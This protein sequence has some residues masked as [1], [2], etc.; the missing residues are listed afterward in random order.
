MRRRFAFVV[1]MVSALTASSVA[2][3]T[4][5]SLGTE[6]GQRVGVDLER[7]PADKT[8]P[9]SVPIASFSPGWTA[10]GHAYTVRLA[11][12]DCRA[13]TRRV[14]TLIMYSSRHD[15]VTRAIG[16]RAIS[17][18]DPAVAMQLNALC[19]STAAQRQQT[20]ISIGQFAQSLRR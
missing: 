2:A 13:R 8:V 9:F 6:R 15:P 18:T 1:G 14:K 19:N 4:W 5:M 11:E 12:F 20:F 3:D 16:E 7:V 10:H 17:D